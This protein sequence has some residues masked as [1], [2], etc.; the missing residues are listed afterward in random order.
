MTR[1]T[2]TDEE[3][4]LRFAAELSDAAAKGKPVEVRSDSRLQE[5]RKVH[6]WY[7]IGNNRG[8]ESYQE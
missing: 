1:G 8:P 3:T 6:D 5:G 7:S 2:G 4:A